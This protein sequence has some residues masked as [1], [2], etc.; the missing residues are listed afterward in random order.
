MVREDDPDWRGRADSRDPRVSGRLREG[1][2]SWTSDG[3]A[4]GP[5]LPGL[6]PED[7][8]RGHTYAVALP[9]LFV[10]GHLD[11]ARAMRVLPLGP[12][13]TLVEATWLLPSEQIG[14]ADLDRLSG[15]ARRVIAEDA[16]ACEMN[17]RGLSAAPFRAGTLMQEEYEV[18]AFHAWV[19]ARLGEDVAEAGARSDRRG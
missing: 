9:S 15:L 7:V 5:T 14:H 16:A 19:R 1:A 8:A 11:H 10:V 13:R 12:D 4:T 18:H 6:S 2:E 3:R 17:Q